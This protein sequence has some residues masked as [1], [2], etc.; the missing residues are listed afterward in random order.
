MGVDPGSRMTGYGILRFHNNQYHHITH[1]TINVA[2]LPTLA[3]RLRVIHETL[4]ELIETHKPRTV[5]IEQAFVHKNPKTALILGQARGAIIVAVGRAGLSFEEYT[6]RQ[7]KQ[8][9]VGYGA[10]GKE[11]VQHMIKALLNLE[12][13]PDSDAADALGV[14]ITHCQTGSP[15]AQFARRSRTRKSSF[16]GMKI[17]DR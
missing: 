5:A 9:I 14:A 15:L 1:G 6:P 10:A 8:A 3:Q 13:E 11:Q 17:D 16:R 12:L 4:Y 2:S 7:V